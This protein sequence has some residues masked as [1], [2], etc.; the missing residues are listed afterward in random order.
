MPNIQQQNTTAINTNKR[1]REETSITFESDPPLRISRADAKSSNLFCTKYAYATLPPK[2]PNHAS[3]KQE[4]MLA[5]IASLLLLLPLPLAKT[6]KEITSSSLS[7]SIE[8]IHCERRSQ[9]NQKTLPT[10]HPPSDSSLNLHTSLHTRKT[11]EIEQQVILA[12]KIMDATKQS[13]QICI[14]KIIDADELEANSK[15]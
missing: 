4:K 7:R 12:N 5:P 1:Q 6:T 9:Y 8:S 13:L 14:V 10:S 15:L 3:L 2:P 11:K